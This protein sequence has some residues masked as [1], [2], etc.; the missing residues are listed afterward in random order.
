MKGVVV[1]VVGVVVAGVGLVVFLGRWVA[2]GAEPRVLGRVSACTGR[3]WF[4]GQAE[5][6][7]AVLSIAAEGIAHYGAGNCEQRI[8]TRVLGVLGVLGDARSEIERREGGRGSSKR[9]RLD[10]IRS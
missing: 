8:G 9:G 2:S 4:P 5:A 10:S 6:S 1:V 3:F 7:Q